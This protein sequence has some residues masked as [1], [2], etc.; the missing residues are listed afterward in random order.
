VKYKMFTPSG[1]KD[2]DIRKFDFV[3]KTQF[4]RSPSSA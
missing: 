1:Y 3:V 4:L 2:M